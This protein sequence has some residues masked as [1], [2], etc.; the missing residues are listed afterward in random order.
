MQEQNKSSA[1]G[2]S[3]AIMLC[4][5]LAATIFTTVMMIENNQ[6]VVAMLL[7]LL[8]A[9]LIFLLM[10]L[11]TLEPNQAAVLSFFG[12]YVGTAKQTGLRWNNPLFSKRKISLRVRNFESGRLKVNDLEGAPIEIAAIIVWHVQDSA[13]AVFNVD[14]YESFVQ[15]QAESALRTIAGSYPYDQS[16]V[17]QPA[18]RSHSSQ[19]IEALQK[20]VQKRLDEAGVK[21][22]EVRISHLAYSPEV[23]QA[24]L[25]R[26]QAAAI[27]AARERIV[28]GAVGMVDTALQSLSDKAIVE[29]NAEQRASLVSNLMVV[30]C[31]DKAATPV[32]N[33]GES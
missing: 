2:I 5:L 25:Q 28:E 33:T 14:D 23:A 10:G 11:Y 31:S 4:L 30:L 9:L 16:G 12:Q 13:E 24:M 1:N 7:A 18:L 3:A 6:V 8:V 20:Q 17:D 15:I 22:L 32:I 26:Q 19:I 27:V 29:F 21:V